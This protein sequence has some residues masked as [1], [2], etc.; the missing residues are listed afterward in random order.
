MKFQLKPNTI[1]TFTCSSTLPNLSTIP[2]CRN[3][4]LVLIALSGIRVTPHRASRV[5]RGSWF[6]VFIMNRGEDCGPGSGQFYCAWFIRA[7]HGS[8]DQRLGQPVT[9]VVDIALHWSSCRSCNIENYHMV[10][11]RT[12]RE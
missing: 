4:K 1:S 12:P 11:T 6:Y 7:L 8:T 9:V 3:I 10:S 2:D 5:L